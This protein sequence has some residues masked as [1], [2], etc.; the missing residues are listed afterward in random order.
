MMRLRQRLASVRPALWRTK[1]TEDMSG[2]LVWR[3]TFASA[4][5][6]RLATELQQNMRL[7]RAQLIK[8]RP[9]RA[10]RATSFAVERAK[11]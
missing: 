1:D 10:T 6:F 7:T 4:S 2:D 11:I 8:T 5:A 9:L 3:R